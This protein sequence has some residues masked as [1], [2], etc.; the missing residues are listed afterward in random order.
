MGIIGKYTLLIILS[1]T[2]FE[3]SLSASEEGLDLLSD[4]KISKVEI[5]KSLDNLRKNGQISDAE[6]EK[7]K[8]ELG[9]MSDSQV[10][11]IKETA[12]GLVKNNPDKALELANAKK[13]D[14]DAVDK[15][16]KELSRPLD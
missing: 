3:S 11:A 1:L 10:N 13:I 5:V 6:Y 2:V 7:A 14:T 16:I 9:G 12:V 4:F 8:K 15:E